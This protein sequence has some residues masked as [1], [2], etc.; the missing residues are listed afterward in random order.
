MYNITDHLNLSAGGFLEF[1][2]LK[3][4]SSRSYSASELSEGLKIMG[5]RPPMGSLYPLL[6]RFRQSAFVTNGYEES[7]RGGGMKTYDLTEK[8]R[9]RLRELRSDWNKLNSLISSL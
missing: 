7:E 1:I 5:I 9:S 3:M 2:V 4:L 6:R 8:G